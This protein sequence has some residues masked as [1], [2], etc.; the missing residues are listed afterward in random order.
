MTSE[1]YTFGGGINWCTNDWTSFSLCYHQLV[2]HFF[3]LKDFF[4]SR[5]W[6]RTSSKRYL[7]SEAK[8]GREGFGL[9]LIVFLIFIC[10]WAVQ[11]FEIMGLLSPVINFYFAFFGYEENRTAVIPVWHNTQFVPR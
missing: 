11:L 7:V 8:K 6:N 4:A 10:V 2:A 1:S 5:E 3:T 9:G